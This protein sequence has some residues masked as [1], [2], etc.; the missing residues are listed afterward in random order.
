MGGGRHAERSSDC[1]IFL[2]ASGS[3]ALGSVVGREII[4]QLSRRRDE[5]SSM[6]TC[7]SLGVSEVVS[8]GCL[9]QL[10]FFPP[11]SQYPSKCQCAIG[12]P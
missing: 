11:N 9:V 1:L 7:K 3:E 8:S 6:V 2:R 5:Q 4:K 10:P 12:V